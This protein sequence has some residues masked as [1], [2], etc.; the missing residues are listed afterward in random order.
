MCVLERDITA[1]CGHAP[2]C[3]DV[4]AIVGIRM[5]MTHVSW[6]VSIGQAVDKQQHENVPSDK[7]VFRVDVHC[8]LMWSVAAIKH[9]G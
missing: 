4:N 6:V 8:T 3:S 1:V 7:C 9:L 5:N 2:R